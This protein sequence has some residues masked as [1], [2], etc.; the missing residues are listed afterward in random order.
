VRLKL[1]LRKIEYA[2]SWRHTWLSL[3]EDSRFEFRE[4]E[5]CIWSTSV[6]DLSRVWDRQASDTEKSYHAFTV[7]LGMPIYGDEDEKRNLKNLAK[8]IGH[9][10]QRQVGEWSA[11]HNWQERLAAYDAYMGSKS[12]TLV[13]A[14][15][16]QAKSAHLTRVMTQT[17]VVSLI[18]EKRLKQA[19]DAVNA[20]VE[21]DTMDI[22]RLIDSIDNVDVIVRRATGQPTTFTSS[23]G[24]EVD[25]K[26]QEYIIGGDM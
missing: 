4:V 10:S 12:I 23:V 1:S 9:A 2:D 11:D 15:L 24:E 25:Y 21:V 19:L 8:K 13:E 16:D 20:G 22:K 5:E 18:I 3:P 7:L 26:K 14:S 17:A 6:T